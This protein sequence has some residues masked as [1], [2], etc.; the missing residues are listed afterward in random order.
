MNDPDKLTM[1][2][3]E[4]QSVRYPIG[5]EGYGF[6]TVTYKFLGSVSTFGI[7]FYFFDWRFSRVWFIIGLWNF[8]DVY[9]YFTTTSIDSGIINNEKCTWF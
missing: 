4:I 7:I 2:L 3:V 8:C 1:I 5:L 9:S 6:F